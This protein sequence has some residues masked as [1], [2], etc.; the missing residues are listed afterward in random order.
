MECTLLLTM[1]IACKNELSESLSQRE[2]RGGE[3]MAQP[4]LPH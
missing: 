2:G 4:H 1:M 3:G